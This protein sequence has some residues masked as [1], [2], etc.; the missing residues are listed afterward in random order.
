MSRAGAAV[1]L[2]LE[3]S[4]VGILHP[5]SYAGRTA[6]DASIRHDPDADT[7]GYRARYL[8]AITDVSKN[9]RHGRPA[10]RL[11]GASF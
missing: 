4:H 9:P 2:A 11:Y 8:K 1:N 5:R 7:Y 10:S 6:G 3:K